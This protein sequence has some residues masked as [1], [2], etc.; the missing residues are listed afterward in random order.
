MA[1]FLAPLATGSLVPGLG[2]AAQGGLT[3][4]SNLVGSGAAALSGAT[5][6]WAQAANAAINQGTP[7]PG[8]GQVAAQALGGGKGGA[9][10]SFMDALLGTPKG[11]AALGKGVGALGQ[12]AG[13]MIGGEKG[14][15]VA[16]N[17]GIFG[18]IAGLAPDVAAGVE[19]FTNPNSGT[20]TTPE[21]GSG[22]NYNPG[23]DQL[24]GGQSNL[25][26][27]GILGNTFA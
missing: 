1:G 13:M 22:S 8:L 21:S 27:M 11:I 2:A 18:M 10:K 9:T 20:P 12:V 23:S 5:G 26:Y 25:G 24:N 16:R 17:A 4:S 19:A 6:P 15:E 7:M 14:R 3:I